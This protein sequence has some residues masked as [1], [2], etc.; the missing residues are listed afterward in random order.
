MSN[1][2]AACGPVD[3]FVLPGFDFRCSESMAY[4]KNLSYFDY[5]EFD[6]FDAGG[7]QCNVVTSVT[8]AVEIRTF[9]VHELSYSCLLRSK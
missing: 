6:I 3:G 2:R 1:P 4:T 8:I 5:L 7:L 9:S